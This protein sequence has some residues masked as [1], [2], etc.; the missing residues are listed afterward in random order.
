VPLAAALL[1]LLD[2]WR[3]ARAATLVAG[4]VSLALAIAIAISVEHGRVLDAAGGWLRVDSLGAVFLLAT[5]T[6]VRDGRRVLDRLPRRRAGRRRLRRASPS[7][8]TR[9]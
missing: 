9:C 7:A 4:S 6:A 8:T 3:L 1:T 2:G 5:G